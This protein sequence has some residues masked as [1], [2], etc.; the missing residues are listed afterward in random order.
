MIFSISK[1]NSKKHFVLTLKVV[2]I[3]N[4]LYIA[5]KHN[6]KWEGL[7]IFVIIK[8]INVSI[9]KSYWK[10][11]RQLISSFFKIIFLF[12]KVDIKIYYCFCLDLSVTIKKNKNN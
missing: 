6:G 2:Y 4:L 1:V 8:L 12:N 7:S 10:V 11:N 3:Q 9:T 5:I